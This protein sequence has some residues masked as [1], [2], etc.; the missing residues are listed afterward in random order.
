MLITSTAAICSPP[1]V[2][3]VGI[4]LRNRRIIAAGITSG[5]IGYAIGNYL[6]VA[7]SYLLSGVG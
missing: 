7:V 1:F 4:A 3:M 5:I 2:G 6:G